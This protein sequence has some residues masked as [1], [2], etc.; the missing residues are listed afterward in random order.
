MWFFLWL[1]FIEN[2]EISWTVEPLPLFGEDLPVGISQIESTGQTLLIRDRTRP[3]IYQF[4][5]NGAWIRTFGEKGQGPGELGYAG[6]SALAF[7]NPELW[8]FHGTRL[9]I[10]LNGVY[11]KGHHLGKYFRVAHGY[12]SNTL[13]AYR[14]GI[15]TSLEQGD[16]SLAG[17]VIQWE[18]GE[19]GFRKFAEWNP[20]E[21]LKKKFLDDSAMWA[22]DEEGIYQLFLFRAQVEAYDLNLERVKRMTFSGPEIELCDRNIEKYQPGKHQ[23]PMPHFSDLQVFGKSL[24][25]MCRNALYQVSKTTGEVQRIHYFKNEEMKKVP[26]TED[27]LAKYINPQDYSF[28]SF[29]RMGINFPFFRILQNGTLVLT[30]VGENFG[31]LLWQV[32]GFASPAKESRR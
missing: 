12:S 20:A 23:A 7:S 19:P 8:V 14:G 3:L 25:M 13:A 27:F 11:E 15:I 2:K 26:I 18:Q 24:F 29:M 17:Y 6:T 10:F 1:A 30:S 28:M 5:S 32:K 4:D 9:S 22:S 31:H 21:I 16:G